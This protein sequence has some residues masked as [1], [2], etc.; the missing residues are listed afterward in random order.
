MLSQGS[1][2]SLNLP[3]PTNTVSALWTGQ[4]CGSFTVELVPQLDGFVLSNTG[5][6][7]PPLIDTLTVKHTQVTAPGIYTIQIE[8]K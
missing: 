6:G 3:A 4:D 7:S 1:D 2:F 8:F 5:G